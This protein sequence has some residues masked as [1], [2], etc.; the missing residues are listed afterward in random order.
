MNPRL[1]G[2]VWVRLHKDIAFWGMLAWVFS[3]PG[4]LFLFT[5]VAG[6]DSGANFVSAV[7]MLMGLFLYCA[8]MAAYAVHKGLPPAW[9]LMGLSCVIGLLI[10]R[11]MPKRCRNCERACSSAGFDCPGCGAPL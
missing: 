8:G 6:L 3:L 4:L 9:G 10:L 2:D 5:G 1:P 11:F 7:Y